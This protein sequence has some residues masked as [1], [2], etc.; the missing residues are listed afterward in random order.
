MYKRQGGNSVATIQ[1]ISGTQATVGVAVDG[2]GKL[3]SVTVNTNGTNYRTAPSLIL[4]DPYFGAVTGL[5]I[6]TQSGGLGQ[7]TYT[8][9]QSATNIATN[10]TG[11][12]ITIVIAANGDVATKGDGSP[13]IT[14]V[15]GGSAYVVE[16]GNNT[17][18]FDGGDMGGSSG[19]DDLILNITS[20]SFV[21]PAT[22]EPLLNAS[23]AVSYTHLTLPTILSV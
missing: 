15:N 17:V 10:P 2:S 14:I 8:V 3:S 18:T 4:G 5:S 22:T 9:N 7:G 12:Q 20:L 19:G 11:L 16:G 23:I 1:S 21:N 13:D 6:N